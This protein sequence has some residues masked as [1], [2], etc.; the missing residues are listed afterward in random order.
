MGNLFK[1]LRVDLFYD[2]KGSTQG[3]TR[4]KDN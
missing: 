1:G 2:L 3:R 4:L